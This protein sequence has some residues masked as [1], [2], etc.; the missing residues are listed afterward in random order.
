VLAALGARRLGGALSE[1]LLLTGAELDAA[2]A[3]RWGIL[4]ELFDTVDPAA[5]LLAWY[6]RRL[7]PLSAFALRQATVAARRAS[8]FLDELD[9]ALTA[10]EKLY[11]EK[12]LTSHDGNEG[13]EAFLAK[14]PPQWRNR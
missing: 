12:V 4:T 5:A 1:R 3:E 11:V 8:G 14:R 6:E 2:D 13:V 10:S 9:R 7:R